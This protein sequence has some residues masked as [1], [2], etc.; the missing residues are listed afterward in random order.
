MT[1]LSRWWDFW[2]YRENFNV[3]A[4][5]VYVARMIRKTGLCDVG[6]VLPKV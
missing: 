6:C 2:R 5:R 1:N 4:S 3:M